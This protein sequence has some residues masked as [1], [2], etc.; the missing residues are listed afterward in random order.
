MGISLLTKTRRKL[1]LL[2]K[3][4]QNPSLAVYTAPIDHDLQGIIERWPELPEA[5]KTDIP[6]LVNPDGALVCM[7]PGWGIRPSWIFAA[8][9]WF[10]VSADWRCGRMESRIRAQCALCQ[11]DA[12]VRRKW[13]SCIAVF[14]TWLNR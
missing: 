8:E 2:P 1:S 12:S 3:A 4:A 11:R 13:S 5:V 14:I 7:L 6:A 10:L 9:P